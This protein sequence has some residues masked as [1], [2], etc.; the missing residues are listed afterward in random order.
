MPHPKRRHDRH[1]SNRE[2]G[3]NANASAKSKELHPKTLSQRNAAHLLLLQ[4]SLRAGKFSTIK[5]W[6]NF[7]RTYFV[8]TI[9][10][11]TFA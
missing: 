4:R 2:E 10:V 5:L 9:I 3:L 7:I 6:T 8:L 1:K 11:L